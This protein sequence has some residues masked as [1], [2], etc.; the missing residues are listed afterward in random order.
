MEKPWNFTMDK[1]PEH[2]WTIC[3]EIFLDVSGDLLS[4]ELKSEGPE[5]IFTLEPWAPGQV[6]MGPRGTWSSYVGNRYV[7]NIYIYIHIEFELEL[8]V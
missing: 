8:C 3:S 7:S 4:L 1:H 5:G 2:W 6:T